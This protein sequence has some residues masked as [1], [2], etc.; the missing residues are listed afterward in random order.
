VEL[1]DAILSP[2]AADAAPHDDRTG[3]TRLYWLAVRRIRAADLS[4]A[5]KALI[6]AEIE[7]QFRAARAGITGFP[8]CA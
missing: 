6:L 8:R 3:L 5:G 1:A 4:D 7:A 2:L